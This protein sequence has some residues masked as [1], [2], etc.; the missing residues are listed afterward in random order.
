MP[1]FK[2][3]AELD[4]LVETFLKREFGVSVDFEVDDAL[5][6]LVRD[7]T[8]IEKVH[9]SSPSNRSNGRGGRSARGRTPSSSPRRVKSTSGGSAGVRYRAKPLPEALETLGREWKDYF[10]YPRPAAAT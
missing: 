7:G 5:D 6:K 2:S 10:E 1:Y 8:V 4:L 3:M 9:H